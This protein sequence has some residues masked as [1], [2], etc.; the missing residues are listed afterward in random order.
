MPLFGV[1]SGSATSEA[2]T[3]DVFRYG[4]AAF[5]VAVMFKTAGVPGTTVPTV[6]RPVPET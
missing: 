5:T 6:H 4:P 3:S 2:V 1:E